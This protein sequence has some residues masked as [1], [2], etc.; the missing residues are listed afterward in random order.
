MDD[1]FWRTYIV[2]I[3]SHSVLVD[4][5]FRHFLGVYACICLEQRVP[6]CSINLYGLVALKAFYL[7]W[8]LLAI[9]VIFGANIL[10]DL[11]GIVA[12]HLYYFLTVLYPL[13]GGK[14]ILKTPL[15][16]HRIVQRYRI[17][18][19]QPSNAAAATQGGRDMNTS[20]STSTAFRGRSYRL[21]D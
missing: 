8:A 4:S 17:G 9:D 15:W 6:Q 14:N 12:G 10:P 11:L 3:G 19:P 7:P 5:L 13:A 1:D 16:V 20:S 2:G 18:F 21:T